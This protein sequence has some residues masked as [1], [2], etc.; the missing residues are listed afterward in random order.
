MKMPTKFPNLEPMQVAP[1]GGQIYMETL[2][3]AQWTQAIQVIDSTAWFRCA[4]R[5]VSYKTVLSIFFIEGGD[6]PYAEYLWPFQ[7]Q[8]E[9]V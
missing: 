3:E 7:L 1:P 2:P 4:S 6:F 8:P 9:L 5:N